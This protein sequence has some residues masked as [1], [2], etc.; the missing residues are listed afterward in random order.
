MAARTVL[1]AGGRGFVGS[2]VVR[3][4][5]AAGHLPVLFGP[6]MAEDRLADLAGRYDE[7][8]GSI[9][10]REALAA[11]FADVRPSAVVSCVAHGVGRLGLMRSGEAEADAAFGVNVLGHG[12]LL[13]AA[14]EAGVERVIWTSSTVIY[15]PASLYGDRHVDEDDPAAPTTTYGLTKQLAEAV[16]AFHARR[17]GLAVVG[18]RLPLIL[19]PGLWYQGAASAIADVFAAARAGEE[20]R[21]AFHD[22]PV[23][24]MH[25]AD[26]A[27]AV[28]AV[29]GHEGRLDPVYNLKGFEASIGALIADV[30]RL[31]P[32][33][34]IALDPIE[35]ALLFPLIDGRRLAEATG[36][37]ARHDLHGLVQALLDPQ[38]ESVP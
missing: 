13:E 20:A 34:R 12:K 15:G 14:S 21:I 36:F 38:A 28:L 37:V 23:D 33:C 8:I 10:D 26:V 29:L 30:E 22:R 1:V 35:P 6:A 32:G 17:H 25:V 16:A 5:V 9:E 31:K 24:L 27:D 7:V 2:H 18:L 11:A 19:G 4:L 3:A